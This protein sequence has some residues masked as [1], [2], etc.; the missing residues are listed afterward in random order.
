M[1]SSTFTHGPAI[2][3]G[4]IEDEQISHNDPAKGS[5]NK[6]D[7]QKCLRVAGANNSIIGVSE[8]KSWILFQNGLRHNRTC[9]LVIYFI[10]GRMQRHD[11]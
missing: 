1:F 2:F 6:H 9:W 7:K 4:S 5:S 3:M 11:P 8:R 10:I